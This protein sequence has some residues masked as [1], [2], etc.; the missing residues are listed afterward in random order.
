MRECAYF[1]VRY[2]RAYPALYARLAPTLNR[3][4][5]YSSSGFYAGAYG[6]DFLVFNCTDSLINLDPTTGNFLRIAS[7]RSPLF[8]SVIVSARIVPI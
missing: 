3:L 8:S 2:D 7:E 1:D 5:T 6:A 4:K